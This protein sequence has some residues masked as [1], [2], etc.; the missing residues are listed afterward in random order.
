MHNKGV[1][2]IRFVTHIAQLRSMISMAHFSL[3]NN[4]SEQYARYVPEHL[5]VFY[6]GTPPLTAHT[7]DRYVPYKS[8]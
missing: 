3:Q 4:I 7:P 1:Y 6:L 5:A 2:A 8:K